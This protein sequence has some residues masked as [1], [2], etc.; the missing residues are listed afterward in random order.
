MKFVNFWRIAIKQL[1]LPEKICYRDLIE[2][3]SAWQS[4]MEKYPEFALIQRL[5]ESEIPDETKED[6]SR[7]NNSSPEVYMKL[8]HSLPDKFP[9]FIR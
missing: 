2:K 7:T 8:H 5:L 4:L 1:S 9:S 6:M 3:L